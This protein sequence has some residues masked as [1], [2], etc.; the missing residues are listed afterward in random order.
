MMSEF[1]CDVVKRTLKEVVKILETHN[2]E[3][4]FLGSVVMASINGDLHRNLGD[5]DL[6]VDSGK[7]D[8]LYKELEKLGYYPPGGMF[9][10]GRKYLSLD[11]LE[12]PKLLGVGFFYGKWQADGA[13]VIGN[14]DIKF[15]I[16]A[17]A[18]RKTKYVLDG[19]TFIGVPRETAARG[20]MNSATNPKR[21]KELV[22][23]SEK[24]IRPYPNS[25]IHVNLFGIKVDWIYQSIMQL[26]NIIGEVR[27]KLGM[28]F[29]PWR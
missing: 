1:N 17:Y 28:P 4:R 12:N 2:I 16:E 20:V 7:K 5:L 27:V 19:I 18:L 10:F 11:T 9:A 13:F 23:I 14:R 26:L 21:K 24:G 15:I 8:T 6:I 29:D 22:I 3:Y 25:Y